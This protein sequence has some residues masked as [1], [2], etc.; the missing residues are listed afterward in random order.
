M[1]K[2]R[3]LGALKVTIQKFYRVSGESTQYRG[4]QPDIILPD[5]LEGIKSGE[6]YLDFALPWDTVEAVPFKKSSL[7][8]GEIRELKS[9]SSR[10]VKSSKDFIEIFSAGR[11]AEELR[12]KTLVSLNIDDARKERQEM[13]SFEKGDSPFHSLQASDKK[14]SGMS[15]EERKELWVKEV[16]GDAY[17]G[18]AESVLDDVISLTPALSAN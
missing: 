4:V 6:K 5:T 11:K 3:T 18:E 12:K 14:T 9:R 7:L 8:S 16:S 10:R 1:G 2:Y 15:P 17:V 13:K